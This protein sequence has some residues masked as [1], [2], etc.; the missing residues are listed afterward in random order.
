MVPAL[1]PI[2]PPKLHRGDTVR[3]IAPSQSRGVVMEHDHSG[4]ME[5]RFHDLGLGLT[6]GDHV[7]ERDDFDSAPIGSRVADLHA[8]FADAGVRGILTVIGG[9]NSNELLP[10]L[11]WNLIAQNPKVFCGYSDI[12]ALQMDTPA[13]SPHCL[14]AAKSKS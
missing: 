7:D 4:L 2:Y 1:T 13:R 14:S 8:A 11:D 6:F 3:V 5:A 12:T 9:F 10:H